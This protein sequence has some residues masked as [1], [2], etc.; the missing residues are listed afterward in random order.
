MDDYGTP[1]SASLHVGLTSRIGLYTVY[2]RLAPSTAEGVLSRL[3]A[4]SGQTRA[5]PSRFGAFC[6]WY[7]SPRRPRISI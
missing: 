1:S 5:L 4:R 7:R 3:G 2:A 6:F